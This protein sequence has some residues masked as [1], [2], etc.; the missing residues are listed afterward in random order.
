[1]PAGTPAYMIRQEMYMFDFANP[2]CTLTTVYNNDFIHNE[3][4]D[5]FLSPAPY[6][7]SSLKLFDHVLSEDTACNESI[8][9]TTK[10]EACVINDVARPFEDDLGFTVR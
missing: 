10:N 7:I 8:K 1:M 6:T 9:Y 4:V 3:A 2:V 5:V